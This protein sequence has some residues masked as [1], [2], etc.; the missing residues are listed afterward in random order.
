MLV[1]SVNFADNIYFTIYIFSCKSK[2]IWGHIC[3]YSMLIF[4]WGNGIFMFYIMS[5]YNREG[6]YVILCVLCSK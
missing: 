3:Y 1:K 5:T 2:K 4:G 6:S